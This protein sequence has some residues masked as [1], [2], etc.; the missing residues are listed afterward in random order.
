VACKVCY[1]GMKARIYRIYIMVAIMLHAVPAKLPMINSRTDGY[2]YKNFRPHTS[3]NSL[4]Y[5]A[6]NNI[7]HK[8]D[9]KA[10]SITVI[11]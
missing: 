4:L 1:P 7:E 3:F 5:Q 8:I 6:V 11:V 10:A 9:V 2:V